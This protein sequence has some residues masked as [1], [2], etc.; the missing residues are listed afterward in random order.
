[1]KEKIVKAKAKA[2]EIYIKIDKYT[3]IMLKYI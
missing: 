1:M 3:Q 2:T